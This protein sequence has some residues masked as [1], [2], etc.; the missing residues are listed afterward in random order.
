MDHDAIVHL[1][2]PTPAKTRRQRQHYYANF[3]MIVRQVGNILEA[4]ERRGVLEDTVVIFTSDHGDSLN[5]HGHSQKWSMYEQVVRVPAIVWA[6]GRVAAGVRVT[7]L[8][9]LFDLGPTILELA[10]LSPPK[11]MEARSLRPHIAG[12][13]V[14]PREYVFAEHAG[15]RILDG[16]T[17]MTM[18]RSQRWK[19]VHFA[20]N[21]EGQL[22]DLAD[23]PDEVRNLWH[24]PAQAARKRTLLD[25]ILHWRLESALKTQGWITAIL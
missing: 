9:A 18:V 17:F 4:L 22:F 20:D 6:P 7:D 1:G 24:D 13:P 15:D 3:S 5:D 11:W 10:G 16:T 8:V 14:E 23:D 2:D 12:E 21:E 25:A 19:L